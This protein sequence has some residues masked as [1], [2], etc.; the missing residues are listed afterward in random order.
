MSAEF[1][2][3]VAGIEVARRGGKQARTMGGV[4]N[5]ERNQEPCV[6]SENNRAQISAE[7]NNTGNEQLFISSAFSGTLHLALRLGLSLISPHV[8]LLVHG[9]QRCTPRLEA[10]RLPLCY[11]R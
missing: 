5:S 6:F 1:T 11:L 3:V 8:T 9:V 4:A 7:V 2:P 10:V